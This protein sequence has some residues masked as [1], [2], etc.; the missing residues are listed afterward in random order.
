MFKYK[1]LYFIFGETPLYYKKRLEVFY[2]YR[3]YV[4]SFF[5]NVLR[6]L[7][8]LGIKRRLLRSC[9][10]IF[11]YLLVSFLYIPRY[12]KKISFFKY[13]RGFVEFV[14]RNIFVLGAICFIHPRITTD[15]AVLGHMLSDFPKVYW[16][17]FMEHVYDME[18]FYSGV[19]LP[20]R[21][22]VIALSLVYYQIMLIIASRRIRSM[23]WDY[24]KIILFVDMY[25]PLYILFTLCQIQRT[26]I[27]NVWFVVEDGSFLSYILF[28]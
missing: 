11:D 9:L 2:I 13:Y 10:I 21:V 15:N 20:S 28:E 5:K 27:M 1:V 8:I 4:S 22:A 19:F 18:S 7:K 17:T 26:W 24:I 16:Y 3:V 23:V 25:V 12:F 14:V 6:K